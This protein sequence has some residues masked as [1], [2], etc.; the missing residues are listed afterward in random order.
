MY[1]AYATTIVYAV[2]CHTSEMDRI[3]HA[4]STALYL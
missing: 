4:I 3:S 2:I 1:T